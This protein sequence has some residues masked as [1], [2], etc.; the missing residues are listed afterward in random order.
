M[1]V[2]GVLV[3]IRIYRWVPLRLSIP[4]GAV[5]LWGLVFPPADPKIFINVAALVI[6]GYAWFESR[7]SSDAASKSATIADANEERSK[8]GWAI[9]L[10]PNGDHYVLRN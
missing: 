10:H 6:A 8:Y 2:K 9:T 3:L 5:G 4:L 1:A 7:R